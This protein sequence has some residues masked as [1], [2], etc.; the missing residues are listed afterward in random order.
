[1][2]MTPLRSL[3]CLSTKASSYREASLSYIVKNSLSVDW[4]CVSAAPSNLSSFG[5]QRPKRRKSSNAPVLTRLQQ[6]MGRF[7]LFG[8]DYSMS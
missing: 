1:M 3:L 7:A 8:H 2:I 4:K 6:R 5:G